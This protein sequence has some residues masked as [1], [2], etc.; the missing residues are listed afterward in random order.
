MRQEISCGS[1]HTVVSASMPEEI[2]FGYYGRLN[3]W[4]GNHGSEEL[5]KRARA[6]FQQDTNAS[7]SI[8]DVTWLAHLLG[9]STEKFVAEHTM[10]PY[11]QAFDAASSSGEHGGAARIDCLTNT[12]F[13]LPRAHAYFCPQCAEEDVDFHHAVSWWRRY[14]Q[15][16]GMHWCDKHKVPLRSIQ[17]KEVFGKFPHE[18]S[19]NEVICADSQW[20]DGLMNEP[21]IERFR[22]IQ[23]AFL[24]R[25]RPVN[26]ASVSRVL[27]DRA[28]SLGFHGGRGN[29]VK[30]LLSTHLRNVLD[31]RWLNELFGEINVE[32]GGWFGPIDNVLLGHHRTASVA[33]SMLASAALWETF[34]DAL[35]AIFNAER[36]DHPRVSRSRETPLSELYNLHDA[37]VSAGGRHRAVADR[38]DLPKASVAAALKKSGLPAL[39]ERPEGKLLIAINSFLNKGESLEQAA[40]SHGVSVS[41]LEEFL[42]RTASPLAAALEKI[43]KS[44]GFI[45]PL[46]HSAGL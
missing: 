18:I 20:V 13:R 1:A 31:T 44:K 15:L 33:A 29:I 40:R 45:T 23:E 12:A 25:K 17:K 43:N 14:H 27:R 2:A 9:C 11:L 41:S 7:R 10:V 26:E 16:P 39:G 19:E 4:N 35:N 22:L 21:I 46:E 3:R 5:S 30:P 38:L 42:R 36:D 24:S 37:Y 34:E 28:I 6:H 8:V 32:Q